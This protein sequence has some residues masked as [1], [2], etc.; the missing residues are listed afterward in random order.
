MARKKITTPT[1]PSATP[2]HLWLAGLGLA[3]MAQRQTAATATQAADRVAQ[4][5][6]QALAAVEQAQAK[7]META[8]ELRG[9]IEN[10]VAQAGRNLETALAPLVA[11]FKP[12]NAKRTERRG[13]KPGSKNVRRTAKKVTAKRARKA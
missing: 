4:T 8:G 9:Q 1:P 12:A 10:G 7:L 6:R 2:R 11:R 13:R 5:R 3:V